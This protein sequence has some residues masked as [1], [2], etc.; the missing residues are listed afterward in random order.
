MGIMAGL[1]CGSESRCGVGRS[2][3]AG[4]SKEWSNVDI[5]VGMCMWEL[6]VNVE[7]EVR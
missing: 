6:G 3:P 1:G 4:S 2:V 5:G 7:T